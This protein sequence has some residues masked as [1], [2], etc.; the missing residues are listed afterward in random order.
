MRRTI[1]SLLAF[2]VLGACSYQRHVERRSSLVAYLDRMEASRV[3][4]DVRL[5]L[6]LRVGI[7]FVPPEPVRGRYSGEI[8]T[9]FPPDAETRLLTIVK[10]AFMG[11]DWVSDIMVIPS[12]Y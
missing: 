8:Q 5:Q 2:I 1:A 9:L 6:P 3:N 4:P 10:K 12:S 7:A 11:R